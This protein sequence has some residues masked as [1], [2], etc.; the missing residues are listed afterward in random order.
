[1]GSLFID[2]NKDG[3]GKRAP[4]KEVLS[5]R[6]YAARRRLN[7]LRRAACRLYQSEELISVI[8]KIEAEVD[9][10]GLAVRKDRMLHADIGG[11][12]GSL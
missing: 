5:F 8:L 9:K 3:T 2:G 12:I 10:L 1:M 11:F 4:T 6:A 7:R